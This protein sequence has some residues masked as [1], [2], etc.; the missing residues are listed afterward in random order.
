MSV[1]YGRLEIDVRESLER[2]IRLLKRRVQKDGRVMLLRKRAA[3][4]KPSQVRKAK[5]LEASK[6]I[7]RAMRENVKRMS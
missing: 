3:F 7:R 2:A 6:K 1:S 4:I 5:A